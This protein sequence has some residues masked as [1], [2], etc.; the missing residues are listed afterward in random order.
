MRKLLWI[1][2]SALLAA[3]VAAQAKD[4]VASSVVKIHVTR[5]EPDFARPWNKANP[6]ETGGSGA[7]IEGNRILTNAHV[8]LYASQIF[9]QADQTTER[10]PAKV[11]AIAPGLDLAVIRVEKPA[12]FDGHPPLPL[13]DDI[14]V[15]KQTVSVYGYPIG[16]EQ[17]SVT[18]GI[19][20]RI[21]CTADLLPGV[22]A[23]DPD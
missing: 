2:M 3:P 8:V 22:R 4:P 19:V 14:P 5:R 18:Q 9:V 16:G 23:A 1:A 21:E 7:I 15:V 6:E 13:T 12:F 10:V 17:I 20:S 11:L